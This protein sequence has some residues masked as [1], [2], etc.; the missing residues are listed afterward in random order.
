MTWLDSAAVDE[1]AS[2]IGNDGDAIEPAF[3]SSA[4]L[5]GWTISGL[6]D[7]TARVGALA[8]EITEDVHGWTA[9]DQLSVRLGDGAFSIRL[10]GTME[11]PFG[12]LVSNIHNIVFS[13]GDF[14]TTLIQLA[15]TA[16]QD[17]SSV[18]DDIVLDARPGWD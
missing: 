13:S 12:P 17:W 9:R 1:I 15:V 14:D 16:T 4:I 18:A 6:H 11:S 8:S 3:V 10:L 5:M 7:S 2:S